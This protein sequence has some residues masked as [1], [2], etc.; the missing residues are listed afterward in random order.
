M[1]EVDDL[2]SK[3]ASLGWINPGCVF[4]IKSAVSGGS[5]EYQY[6]KNT[7]REKLAQDAEVGHLFFSHADNLRV[8]NLRYV[9]GEQM[10][11]FFRRWLAEYPEPYLQ[12][13]RKNIPFGWVNQNGVLR[14]TLTDGEVTYPVSAQSRGGDRRNR[15]TRISEPPTVDQCVGQTRYSS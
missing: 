4:H 6:H 3:L 1:E 5:Y 2:L 13:Y 7:G 10:R 14:M 11:D 12:R 9:H 8:V 15:V